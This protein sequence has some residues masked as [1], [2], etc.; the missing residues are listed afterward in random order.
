MRIL[1]LFTVRFAN[2]IPTRAFMKMHFALY[3]FEWSLESIFEIPLK[4]Q[5]N[6][7][8]VAALELLKADP[9][10]KPQKQNLE[11]AAD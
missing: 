3:I 10:C 9:F 1:L 11:F 7:E 4:C 5:M 8:G 2:Q 6:E